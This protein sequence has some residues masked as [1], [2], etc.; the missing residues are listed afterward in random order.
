MFNTV[1]FLGFVGI[2]ADCLD[3]KYTKFDGP[4]EMF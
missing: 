4:V 3:D 1:S 2:F